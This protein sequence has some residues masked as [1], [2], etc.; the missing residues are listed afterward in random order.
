MTTDIT[1]ERSSEALQI[2]RNRRLVLL[3]V[4]ILLAVIGYGLYWWQVE[5]LRVE[6]HNA[7]VA[8]NLVPVTSQ[9]SGIIT[10]VLAE[11]TQF[12]NKG[13]LVMTL[14]AN[15][16]AATL[17]QA[18]GNLGET[19]RR[20]AALYVHRRQFVEKLAARHARLDVIRHDMARYRYV[21]PHGAVPK[22]VVQNAEDQMR[23]L[24][25]EVR[26]TQAELEAL[27]VQIG[28]TTVTE[29][30]AVQLAKYQFVEAQLRYGRQQI[31]SPVAGYV[32]KRKGQVGDRVA[33]G[34]TLMTIVPLDHLWV[35]ANL[36]ETELA[37][38][39]PGQPA[40]VSVDMYGKRSRYHGTVEGLVPGSGSVFATLPPDNATGNFIHI[41]Q[42][43]PVRIALL[44]DELMENPIRPGLSTV[45][46][47]DVSEPGQ[48]VWTSHTTTS[49]P[50]YHTDVFE[51]ELQQA[52]AVARETVNDNLPL[53][54]AEPNNLQPFVQLDRDHGADR[55]EGRAEGSGT[56]APRDRS[57]EARREPYEF[58]PQSMYHPEV[59][60][61][62]CRLPRFHHRLPDR[63]RVF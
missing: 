37:R 5:R 61:L 29:H 63:A 18:R 23:A 19:V 15:E 33:P 35:E 16:A 10:N 13:D 34:M 26:E 47:I 25:A 58:T 51:E 44:K 50:E 39:R 14:D 62:D 57:P 1:N 52:D 55:R 42:R 43:V 22:Q 6:T 36:R 56:I 12:V 24:E 11:E 48:S 17:G 20:I 53:E 28:R 8:G 46:Q 9:V 3:L 54:S 31:H 59:P 27:D 60:I 30:P 49:T 4:G 7:F 40:L 2:R 45:T 41:V 38:V 21:S 32:A